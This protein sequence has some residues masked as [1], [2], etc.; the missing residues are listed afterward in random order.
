MP[1]KIQGLTYVRGK[2]MAARALTDEHAFRLF[3][4]CVAVT[5]RI[6]Q[7]HGHPAARKYMRHFLATRSST[8]FFR[9]SHRVEKALVDGDLKKTNANYRDRWA[10][11]LAIRL[12]GEDYETIGRLIETLE[13]QRLLIEF[14]FHRSAFGFSD[15]AENRAEIE[16]S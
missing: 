13:L 3:C 7:T 9:I 16:A 11:L 12:V 15:A 14:A 1:E 5:Y 8:F 10:R 6:H 4:R 2:R